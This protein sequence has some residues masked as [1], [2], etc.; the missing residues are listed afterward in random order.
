MDVK[1]GCW[2]CG[3]KESWGSYILPTL[4]LFFFIYLRTNSDLCHLQ[5]R[6]I[7][8]YNPD[9]KCLQGGTD[10]G[11]NKAVIFKRLKYSNWG[12]VLHAISLP[13][14][15]TQSSPCLQEHDAYQLSTA[16]AGQV[17]QN[18]TFCNKHHLPNTI[19]LVTTH[20]LP[21]T[22]FAVNF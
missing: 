8:F 13:S 9:E 19:K 15:G 7:G 20:S 4:Y 17:H 5:H 1:L 3:R 12:Y 21:M 10:W 16:S 6:L 18:Y 11:L 14:K 22:L 2:H